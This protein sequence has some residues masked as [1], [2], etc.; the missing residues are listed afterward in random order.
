[1]RGSVKKRGDTEL[2]WWRLP[3]KTRERGGKA[4]E[5]FDT[6]VSAARDTAGG[7]TG[8]MGLCCAIPRQRT[9]VFAQ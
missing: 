7:G 4:R 8:H 1:M 2:S 5:N 3:R 6:E 9:L